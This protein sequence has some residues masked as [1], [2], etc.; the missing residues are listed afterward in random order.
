MSE[1][2]NRP[3]PSPVASAAASISGGS[4]RLHANESPFRLPDDVAEQ[5]GQACA[6]LALNRYPDELAPAFYQALS[7]RLQVPT[8]MLLAGNGSDE[9]ILLLLMA[10]G[11]LGRVLLP[12]PSFSMYKQCADSLQLCPEELP[13][14]ADWQLDLPLILQAAG[15]D[16]GLIFVC[17][18]NNPTGNL[19]ARADV[20]RLLQE[21]QLTV[22]V[23][24][25]YS[26]FSGDSLLPELAVHPRLIILRTL[27]KAYGLA[28]IRL[29]YL[30]AQ[31]AMV[32]GVDRVRSPF[33]LNSLSLAVGRIALLHG[34][35][36]LAS[37]PQIC[38]ERD[39]L[40]AEL[41]ALPAVSVF[42][43]VTNFLLLRLPGRAV[44]IWSRLRQRGI[45][46]RL[47]A[48]LDDCLRVSIG[49]RAENLRLLSALRQSLWEEGY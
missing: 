13:L 35:Q 12:S 29:G 27:S 16:P 31:P 11:R 8:E 14:T 44:P 39:W 42:P 30:I 47:L 19:F 32:Q 18:P 21:T 28:G 36:L 38:A 22:V 6:D 41:A 9:L 23:D 43:S 10:Y 5:I 26:E 33:N 1:T 4:L 46:V 34:D 15:Q 3:I 37:V 45:M 2:S 17:R 25:A 7:N 48:G 20:L 49:Q 24:E 40:F